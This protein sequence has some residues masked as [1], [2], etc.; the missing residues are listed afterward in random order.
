MPSR[1]IV[2]LVLATALG[3]VAGCA[4]ASFKGG[5]Y[6]DGSVRYRVGAL[7]PEWRAVSSEGADLAFHRA[8][9]GTISVNS[10]CTEYEDVPPAALLNHLLFETTDR[11]FVTE[12]TIYLDGRGA[13][14]V[15]VQLELDGVP[16]E[17]EIY[18]LKKDGCV[19]DLTHVRA[20]AAASAARETFAAFVRH[21][22][23]LEVRRHG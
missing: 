6:A 22:V 3:W 7:D 23:V 17:V 18:L 20:K 8:G 13:R 2:P 4:G 15:V 9:M 10:T 16:L 5:L 1:A 14:H 12:E 19:F 21:F 11:R